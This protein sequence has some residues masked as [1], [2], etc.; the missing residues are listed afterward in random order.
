[1]VSFSLSIGLSDKTT[2]SNFSPGYIDPKNQKLAVNETIKR[3]FW[4]I[5][6]G[7]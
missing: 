3:E 6:N 1:M 7:Q 4:A 2:K 5:L